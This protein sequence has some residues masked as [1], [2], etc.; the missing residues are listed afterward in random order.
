MVSDVDEME[1]NFFNTV[2]ELHFFDA[3][4]WIGKSNKQGVLPL[5]NASEI[6]D[7]MD[8][9]GIEKALVSHTLS[10]FSSPLI[11]NEKLLEDISRFD[12]LIGCAILLPN[13]TK[14]IGSLDEYIDTMIKK[15][16]RTVRLFPKSHN[17]SL[18]EWS[19]AHLLKKLDGRK[20]PLFIWSRETDWNTLHTI[21]NT[22]PKLPIILEQC[23]E[24]AYRNLRFLFPLLE[25]HRNLYV[26]TNDILVYLGIDEI[27]RR[28]SANRLIFGTQLPI[29]DPYAFMGLIT[30][31]DFSRKEKEDIACNNLENLI[32]GVVL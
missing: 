10:R 2:K 9:C 15:G 7:Q 5:D 16:V 13:S 22:Y 31:G 19:S 25:K 8:M 6:I 14:E 27:V 3:N 20:I 18:E 17:Y 30:D 28:F 29:N 4:C 26:E 21:C 24:E 23:D 32:K 1:K 11:G 12:R